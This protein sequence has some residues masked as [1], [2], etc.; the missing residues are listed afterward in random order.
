MGFLR[1]LNSTTTSM[2]ECADDIVCSIPVFSLSHIDELLS[3][4]RSPISCEGLCLDWSWKDKNHHLNKAHGAVPPLE[5]HEVSTQLDI[6]NV[7]Y[8]IHL[9]WSLHIDY[10]C[11]KVSQVIH[12]WKKIK[13][14]LRHTGSSIFYHTMILSVLELNKPS[15][16][17]MTTPKSMRKSAH[18]SIPGPMIH[19]KVGD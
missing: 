13:A 8:I 12:I 19:R 18:P 17:G 3:N 14:L 2:I 11:K 9:K 15:I 4:Q 5:N 1:P 10:I 7:A 6:L 16:I